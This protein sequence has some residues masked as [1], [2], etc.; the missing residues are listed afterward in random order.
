[1]CVAG[2]EG[3]TGRAAGGGAGWGGGTGGDAGCGGAG[4]TGG[5]AGFFCSGGFT[6]AACASNWGESGPAAAVTS[7][8]AIDAMDKSVLISTTACVVF[9]GFIFIPAAFEARS[10]LDYEQVRLN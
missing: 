8:D 2:G 3:G 4:W 1:M 5:A 10:G 7:V 6:G 9:M